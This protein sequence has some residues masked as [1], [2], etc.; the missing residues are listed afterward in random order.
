MLGQ[1]NITH[2]F[3]GK[4]VA[5]VAE[6]AT[7]ADMTN[8]QLGV[9]KV[10]VSTAIDGTNDLAAGDRFKIVLKDVGG[11]L[12]ESPVIS[13]DNIKTKNAVLY[14]ADTEQKTY[15]GYNGT[16][17][18]IAVANSDS[19]YIHLDRKDGSKTW[20][21]HTLY[22]LLA[23]YKSDA[24]A[25]QTEIADALVVNAVKNL[26]IEKTRS[27]RAV[28]QVGRINSAAVTAA[29]DFLGN[30][31]VVK[32]TKS[33]TVAESG[34]ADDGG[35]YNA[36][37]NLVVGDYV[38]IG[39]VGGGT[40][41]TSNVYKVTAISGLGTALATVTVDIP[42]LEASGTYAAATSD[43]EVIPA[44]TAAAANWGLMIQSLAVKFV[45]GLFKNTQITFDVS[46]SEAFGSTLITKNTAAT[47]GS[48]TYEEV[49][50][51]EWFLKGNRGEPYRVADYPLSNTLNATSGKVYD[52]IFFSFLDKNSTDIDSEVLSFISVLIYTENEATSTVHTDL[53]DVLNIT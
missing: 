24:T 26:A 31:T 15:V 44:A 18:S 34:A 8:G 19:Y 21:E 1:K 40:A 35:V 7:R 11:N 46:L 41:L 45:P 3:V 33:F 16:T 17:G 14:T 53:K 49:A 28:N 12:V 30:A 51:N 20:G 38:R 48:G 52:T 9:F 39:S 29:N 6:T 32:G 37:E 36:A 5:P 13:Y 42:I 43:I 25:T 23:G 4:D 10:G 2:V 50:E 47:K 22:K 27:G